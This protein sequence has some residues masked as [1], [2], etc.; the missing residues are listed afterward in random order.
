MPYRD[1]LPT[2]PCARHTGAPAVAAC[3]RCHRALCASCMTTRRLRAECAACDRVGARRRRW[4][5]LVAVAVAIGLGPATIY[6]AGAVA[7]AP[8][9]ISTERTHAARLDRERRLDEEVSAQAVALLRIIDDAR[10]ER[11]DSPELFLRDRA[12]TAL[13]RGQEPDA[14]AAELDAFEWLVVVA[15][16]SDDLTTAYAARALIAKRPECQRVLVWRR[17]AGALAIAAC[18]RGGHPCG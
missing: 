16:V 4:L 11:L 9:A 15:T 7:L 10:R 3:E 12:R 18:G 6:T 2:R 14:L 17:L 1:A 5:G 8:P 13:S